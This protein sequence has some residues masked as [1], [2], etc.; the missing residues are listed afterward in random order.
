MWLGNST[1]VVATFGVHSGTLP[2]KTINDTRLTLILESLFMGRHC[3]VL[4]RSRGRSPWTQSRKWRNRPGRTFWKCTAS[5]PRRY[6]DTSSTGRRSSQP[7]RTLRTA[8]LFPFYEVAINTFEE[9][10]DLFLVEWGRQVAGFAGLL[11]PN[12]RGVLGT[13][14]RHNANFW[15]PKLGV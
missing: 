10:V 7:R 1:S 15:E 9:T 3:S 5:R 12:Q 4:R 6:R 11:E 2:G 8:T 13:G 14:A